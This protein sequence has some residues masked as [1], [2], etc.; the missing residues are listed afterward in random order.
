MIYMLLSGSL[1]SLSPP[2]E[3]HLPGLG[4]GRREEVGQEQ[5]E[6][7]DGPE[8]GGDQEASRRAVSAFCL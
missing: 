4:E 6:G 1:C 5:E 8:S 3:R 2:G 7:R